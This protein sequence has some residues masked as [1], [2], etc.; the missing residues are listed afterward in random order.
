MYIYCR[1]SFTLNSNFICQSF[2]EITDHWNIVIMCYLVKQYFSAEIN[3]QVS[4][5]NKK[6]ISTCL[7]KYFYVIYIQGD[8]D[9]I[10]AFSLDSQNFVQRFCVLSPGFCCGSLCS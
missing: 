7:C 10:E 8:T 4:N 1:Y 5:I 2:F 9:P 6:Y 3:V